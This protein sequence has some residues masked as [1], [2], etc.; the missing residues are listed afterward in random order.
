MSLHNNCQ[1]INT[2]VSIHQNGW[3]PVHKPS[4]HNPTKTK[5]LA[6]IYVPANVQK[7]LRRWAYSLTGQQSSAHWFGSA[8]QWYSSRVRIRA[9][10]PSVRVR[11]SLNK[12]FPAW[13]TA[14][15]FGGTKG[16]ASLT[17]LWLPLPWWS[18][19]L[20]HLCMYLGTNPACGAC[21]HWTCPLSIT[22]RCFAVPVE[23]AWWSAHGRSPA[24]T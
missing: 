18:C 9:K 7:Y 19:C 3:P 11:P 20:Y 23:S 6:R 5:V 21:T 2:V 1:N 16:K 4:L 17:S 22:S 14:Y 8:H 10:H 24:A 15:W 12:L 13:V